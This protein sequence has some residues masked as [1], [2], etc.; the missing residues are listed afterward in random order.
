M[1]GKTKE[2]TEVE[3]ATIVGS[4]VRIQIWNK[5]IWSWIINTLLYRVNSNKVVQFDNQSGF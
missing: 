1:H 3:A 2:A 5:E 4:T